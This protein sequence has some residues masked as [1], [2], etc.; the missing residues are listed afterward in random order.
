MTILRREVGSYKACFSK[1]PS[2][3]FPSSSS[4]SKYPQRAGQ[5]DEEFP[6]VGK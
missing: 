1:Y 6:L 2:S 5:T 4:P 3:L